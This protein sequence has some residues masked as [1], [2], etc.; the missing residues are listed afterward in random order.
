MATAAYAI[1]S[2]APTESR[3]AAPGGLHAVNPVPQ[4]GDAV[5]DY[6]PDA[7]Q[8]LMLKQLYA[9]GSHGMLKQHLYHR[10]PPRSTAARIRAL[11][12]L[13]AHGLVEKTT[14]QRQTSRWAT[15]WTITETG[16]ASYRAASAP[17]RV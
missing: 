12:D 3:S 15:L 6:T 16:K 5:D 2:P 8:L 13:A 1:L 4:V 10:L 9:V 14:T 7:L 11:D 17:K